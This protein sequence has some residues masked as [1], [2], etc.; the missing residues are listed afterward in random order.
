MAAVLY[1]AAMYVDFLTSFYPFSLQHPL[2]HNLS[3]VVMF[4]FG[5]LF[6]WP[7]LAVDQLPNRPSFSTRIIALFVG[8]PFEVFLG[9]AVMNMAQ[10]IASEH[11]LADTHAGGAVFWGASMLITFAAALAVLGQW[12]RQEERSA[13]R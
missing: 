13:A 1:Y 4:V 3:H 2:V 8:M 11:T 9:L 5:C 7:M 10:P 6:W 12:M